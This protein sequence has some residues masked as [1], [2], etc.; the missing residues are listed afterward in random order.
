MEE[1][2]HT[3]TQYD[4][5]TQA[6]LRFLYLFIA[7]LS[8]WS[9][10]SLLTFSSTESISFFLTDTTP[11]PILR[12]RADIKFGCIVANALLARRHG[13]L[14]FPE[15]DFHFLT[16][17]LLLICLHVLV[18]KSSVHSWQVIYSCLNLYTKKRVTIWVPINLDILVFVLTWLIQCSFYPLMGNI[19]HF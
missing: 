8:S 11:L 14:S 13:T 9:E 7:I 1:R 19:K 15:S 18:Y 5:E 6:V 3:E 10:C 16:P 2:R 12:P 17:F 4:E